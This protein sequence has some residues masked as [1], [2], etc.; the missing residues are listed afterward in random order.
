MG[1]RSGGEAGEGG[2]GT[3]LMA[4]LRS[5]SRR[6]GDRTPSVG[7]GLPATDLLAVLALL[8]ALAPSAAPHPPRTYAVKNARYRRVV[9]PLCLNVPS[10]GASGL[11]AEAWAWQEQCRAAP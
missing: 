10:A 2:G 1:A 7:R 9:T 3:S 4:P 5:F 6:L 8:A 11:K